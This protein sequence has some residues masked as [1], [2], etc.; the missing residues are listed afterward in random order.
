MHVTERVLQGWMAL[1]REEG[2]T[3]VMVFP[4]SISTVMGLPSR[5]MLTIWVFAGD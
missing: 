3:S 4:M 1:G 5:H 2:W